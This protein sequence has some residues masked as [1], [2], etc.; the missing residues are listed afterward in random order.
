MNT[1]EKWYLDPEELKLE[2]IKSKELNQPTERF[3]ELMLLLHDNVLKHKKFV[4]CNWDL[5]EELKS[6]SLMRIFKRGIVTVDENLSAKKLFNYFSTAAMFNMM[7]RK[8]DLYNR[9]KKENEYKDKQ[10][11]DYKRVLNGEKL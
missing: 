10:I 8:I 3:G 9:R 7:R 1:N 4:M 2:I 5:K 11:N 6:Y